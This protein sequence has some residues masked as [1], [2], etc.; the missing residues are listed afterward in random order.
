MSK[1]LKE[2][3][4]MMAR[5]MLNSK[6]GLRVR[7]PGKAAA[8]EMFRAKVNKKKLPSFSY[9]HSHKDPEYAKMSIEDFEKK[10]T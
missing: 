9:P 4:R 10:Y 5:K 7:M 8:Y 6:A 3:R 1:E 2:M